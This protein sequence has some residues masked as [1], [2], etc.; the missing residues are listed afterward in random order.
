MWVEI[1]GARQSGPDT[2]GC[3]CLLAGIV[4]VDRDRMSVATRGVLFASVD[5]RGTLAK[6]SASVWKVGVR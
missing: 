4:M 1:G 3:I 5:A 6:I 2:E